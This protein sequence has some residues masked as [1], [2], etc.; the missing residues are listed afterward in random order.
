MNKIIF[1][2]DVNNA[3][4]SWSA[5]YKLQQG[6][7]IDIRT[8]P[9]AIGGDEASRR[10]VILAKSNPA[11][12]FGVVTG[13]SIFTAK[14][15]CPELK[16]YPSDFS[17]YRYYS[18]EVIRI[19]SEYTHI[20]EKYSIDES[21]LDVTNIVG[22]N[23]Y[24]LAFEIKEKIKKELGFT[25]NVGI[26]NN[27]LLAKMASEFEKPDKIHTLFPEEIKQKL[28]PL[29][30]GELF[31][32]GK[33]AETRLNNMYIFTIGDLANYDVTLL[34]Q[35]F[36]SYGEMIWKYAN[37]M[38]EA[39]V[40]YSEEEAKIISNSVTLPTDVQS[41]AEANKVL[42]EIAEKLCRRL[43]DMNKY[44]TTVSVH[45]RTSDFINYSHQKKLKTATNSTKVIYD[46]VAE[47]FQNKWQ[48]EP[49]RLLGISLSNLCDEVIEQTSFFHN[50]N[51]NIKNQKIDKVMDA[52]QDKY[53]KE[54]INRL[55]SLNDK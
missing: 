22:N 18:Q 52:I 29:P 13:E 9:S 43:R 27:K 46:I 40:N 33:K 25:V 23:P 14:K 16:L 45:I 24:A 20:I 8:I 32:V 26:S 50:S 35:K 31:M 17:I 10:G 3:F 41:K 44:C 55:S 51:N 2:I 12:K 42:M 47:L 34:K 53:G 4:L 28:W 1:H 7:K 19:F 54:V 11:K 5:V 38:G 49:I 6:E 30:V 39:E 36:K 37:G 48:Y 21:F 15:K